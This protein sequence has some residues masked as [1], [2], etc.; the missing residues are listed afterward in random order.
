MQ[1][2]LSN[3][4]LSTSILEYMKA[5]KNTAELEGMVQCHI[6]DGAALAIGFSYLEELVLQGQN[7][8]EYAFAMYLDNLRCQLALSKGISFETISASGANAAIVH[9]K[10]TETECASIERENI[11][12]C[13]SGGQ[14]LDGTTDVTRTFHWAQ[15]VHALIKDRYTRVLLGNLDLERLVWPKSKGIAGGHMDI[16]ARRRLWEVELDYGHGT[17]HGVGSYLNVHEGP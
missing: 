14:Y 2:A 17:G 15:E 10:P 11:F 8:T 6:R 9:Y 7:I 5:V 12:L 1:Q 13:D 16:L 4:K 3:V